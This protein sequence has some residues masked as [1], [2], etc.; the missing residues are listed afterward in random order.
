VKNGKT[1]LI[2]Q[3]LHEALADAWVRDYKHDVLTHEIIAISM[4]RIMKDQGG[5]SKPITSAMLHSTI[6]KTRRYMEESHKCTLWLVRG[7]GYKIANKDETAL[8]TAGA[9]KRTLMWADRTRRLV[10]ITD[11]QYLP[12][13]LKRV[14]AKNSSNV[15]RL[16]NEGR[17]YVQAFEEL[18]KEQRKEL[19]HAKK[20]EGIKKT[21][22]KEKA[23]KKSTKKKARS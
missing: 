7:V 4:Q 22:S 13:A 8:Y 23:S 5:R 16:A 20:K 3:P 19:S 14:F 9:I 2:K 12:S 15:A 11:R 18:V 21:N 1:A 10:P 6:A 17:G